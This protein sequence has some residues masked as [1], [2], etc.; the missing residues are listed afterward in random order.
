[1]RT[2]SPVRIAQAEWERCFATHHEPISDQN[3]NKIFSRAPAHVDC[4]ADGGGET[5]G[6]TEGH[7]CGRVCVGAQ[8]L[9]FA[10]TW[11]LVVE[12]EDFSILR[13]DV[14]ESWW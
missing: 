11:T 3:Q 12:H 6:A 7:R 2:S 5:S 4:L 8:Q 9:L 14:A 10:A 1:M 13:V